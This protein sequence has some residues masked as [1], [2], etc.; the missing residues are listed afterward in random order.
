MNLVSLGGTI[1]S[2]AELDRLAVPALDPLGLLAT[3][4]IDPRIEVLTTELARIPSMEISIGL[5]RQVAALATEV[6]DGPPLVVT[7][8]TDTIDETAFCLELLSGC[9]A[10]LVVTGALRSASA[11]GADGP[12]NLAA[13]VRVAA[14]AKRWGPGCVVV[15]NDEIHAA[16]F[17]RKTHTSAPSAFSSPTTGRLGWVSEAKVRVLMKPKPLKRLHPRPGDRLPVVAIVPVGIDDPVPGLERL[18]EC[19]V[20]GIV[21]ECAG[22]GHV[23]ARV[24]NRIGELA[25]AIP[26]M[27]SSRVSSGELLSRSYGFPGSESD[28][29]ARGCLSSGFLDPPKARLLLLLALASTATA[30]E[31]RRLLLDSYGETL[32]IAD[33][34]TGADG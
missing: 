24:A 2:L 14:A 6:S 21:L 25:K 29:L 1:S 28:L 34:D 10:T 19:G 20:N 27:Y 5:L 16:R 22:G 17:V 30:N 18:Y 9:D 33:A 15:L 13:A 12:A 4:Q 3:T 31:C 11:V 23:N 26:V 8:G 7:Q 32:C